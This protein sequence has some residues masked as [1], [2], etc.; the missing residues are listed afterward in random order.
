MAESSGS[1]VHSPNSPEESKFPEKSR[2]RFHLLT[3]YNVP[4]AP[5]TLAC[6]FTQL[7]LRYARVLASLGHEVYYYGTVRESPFE[8]KSGIRYRDCLTEEA[9]SELESVHGLI[10]HE[11]G[12]VNSGDYLFHGKNPEKIQAI[13]PKF[14]QWYC[15]GVRRIF[16]DLAQP[17]DFV[18]YFYGNWF[19]NP[20]FWARSDPS[21][22][23][24]P[25]RSVGSLPSHPDR[26]S[27]FSSAQ[28]PDRD[29]LR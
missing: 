15:S 22:P 10:R 19:L 12:S 2:F 16:P 20:R 13:A 11:V 26:D 7:S 24:P 1:L 18:L 23:V 4:S 27:G 21:S 5:E 17:G 3:N 25:R 14:L 28:G 8:E 29:S 9:G 6:A